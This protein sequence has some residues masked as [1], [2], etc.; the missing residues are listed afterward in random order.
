MFTTAIL[1]A[2]GRVRGRQTPRP[3]RREK[4]LSRLELAVENALSSCA[5]EVVV[6]LGKRVAHA[7][8]MLEP[9]G[10]LKVVVD[11]VHTEKRA[12][13]LAAGVRA[14]SPEATAYYVEYA[15]DRAAASADL[16]LFLSAAVRE[17]K[18]I[19]VR[20][21]SGR[22]DIFPLLFLRSVRSELLADLDDEGLRRAV[23][24]DPSR[25]CVVKNEPPVAEHA[26]VGRRGRAR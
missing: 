18:P 2:G 1:I 11:A 26:P 6:V 4:G 7:R 20:R 23:E 16:D 14:A 12:A 8:E 5:D 19:A 3:L 22:A 21:D 13:L 24:R 25:L 17:G 10:R 9:R 15:D